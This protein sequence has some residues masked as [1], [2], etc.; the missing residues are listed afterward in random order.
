M[1]K[2]DVGADSFGSQTKPLT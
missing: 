1:I 2:N